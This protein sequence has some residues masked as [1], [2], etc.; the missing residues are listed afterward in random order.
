M[1]P[2]P[3]PITGKKGQISFKLPYNFTSSVVLYAAGVGQAQ[4]MFCSGASSLSVLHS[5][6]FK[7]HNGQ[8]ISVHD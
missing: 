1:G 3:E 4:Q 5:D 6:S 2:G 7:P 8:I